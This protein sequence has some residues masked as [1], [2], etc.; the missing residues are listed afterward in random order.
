MN[1]VIGLNLGCGNRRIGNCI[2]VDLRKTDITDMNFNAN[3]MPYP[4][5]NERFEIIFALDIIEHLDDVMKVM[6]ELHRI[7]KPGGVI[8]IRTTAWDTEQSYRDP[9]HKH[10][11][12]LQTFDVF[13]PTK[14]FGR[15]YHWYTQKKLRVLEARRDGEEL[16]FELYKSKDSEQISA[17]EMIKRH[18]T[19]D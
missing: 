18:G 7:L 12:T 2:N 1:E 13:D 15:D 17:E 6:E 19:M 4:F 5:E 16:V 10:W 8:H 9:T 14:Q 3:E 11:F